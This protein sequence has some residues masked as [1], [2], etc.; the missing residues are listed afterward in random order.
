M[1]NDEF[2][3]LF[4]HMNKRF[5]TL[6]GAISKTASSKDMDIVLNT[7][8]SMAKQLEITDDKRLVMGHQLE[9]L[10]RWTHELAQKIGYELKI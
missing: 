6:D 7:L 10:D 8:D 1:A 2:D 3:K 4:K 5:D 9:R